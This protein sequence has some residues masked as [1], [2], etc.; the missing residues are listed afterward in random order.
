MKK[1]II[2]AVSLVCI[3]IVGLGIFFKNHPSGAAQQNQADRTAQIN[4]RVFTPEELLKYDGQNGNPAYIAIS[5]IVYDVTNDRH[6]K[7]GKHHDFS[8]GKDLTAD[9]PHKTSI[10]AK[11]PIVGKLSEK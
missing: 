1:I 11:V 5:G 6:W 3:C 10:L 2:I 8:A 4:A 9:F 7:N